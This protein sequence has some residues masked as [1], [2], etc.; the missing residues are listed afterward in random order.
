MTKKITVQNIL[1]NPL[2]LNHDGCYS[3]YDWFCSDKSLE[4]KATKL[5][6]K[7]KKLVKLGVIDPEKTVVSFKNN[8]P[9]NGSLFD[10]LRF[11]DTDGNYLGVIVPSCGHDVSKGQCGVY[12][13][14][15]NA[16][17][18]EN[19]TQFI[20]YVKENNFKMNVEK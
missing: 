16:Q 5:M 4:N 6:Q 10:D 20:Q 1:D 14:I 2:L 3:F 15:G 18:F 13:D 19:W 8:C 9:V 11:E 17:T 12:Q 7:V